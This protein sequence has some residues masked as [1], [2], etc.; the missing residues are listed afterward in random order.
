MLFTNLIAGGYDG[1]IYLVNAKGQNIAGRKVYRTIA[2][3][4]NQVDLG[5]VTIPAGKVLSL[6]DEFKAKG[7]R[8]MLL[9]TSGFSETGDEG[10]EME[11]ELVKAAAEAGIVILGPNTMGICNPHA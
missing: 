11:K 4:P 10:R 8:Y 3:I 2:D 5:V 7:I 1:E 9:I 6:I